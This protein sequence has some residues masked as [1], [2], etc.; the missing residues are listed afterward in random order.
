MIPCAGNRVLRFMFWLVQ[1]QING[2]DMA[3]DKCSV[4]SQKYYPDLN[5]GIV[6]QKLS[7]LFISFQIFFPM[8]LRYF[9]NT[10]FLCTNK[11]D[12]ISSVKRIRRLIECIFKTFIPI[13]LF[14]IIWN[15]TARKR[16]CLTVLVKMEV[17]YR[18]VAASTII[19]FRHSIDQ[20][21]FDLK[22]DVFLLS[23]LKSHIPIE[24]ISTSKIFTFME[25]AI[26][27]HLQ[28]IDATISSVFFERSDSLF[29]SFQ[30]F[31][32]LL[33]QSFI[34]SRVPQGSQ[35]RILLFQ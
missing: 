14:V 24:E 18:R 29:F 3:V 9:Y 17:G 35:P 12:N 6:W 8:F 19:K 10:V 7:P 5:I 1:L 30:I 33:L 34:S 23:V 21:L 11:P 32:K 25:A 22:R 20:V 4:L 27:L 15:F 13:C 31:C 26:F 28:N 16:T 2:I